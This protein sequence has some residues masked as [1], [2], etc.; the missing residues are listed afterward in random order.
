V[1]CFAGAV[2]AFSSNA[3]APDTYP[4]LLLLR[5]YDLPNRESDLTSQL[6]RDYMAL[7]HIPSMVSVLAFDGRVLHQNGE[8]T[9]RGPS[10]QPH[11][12]SLTYLDC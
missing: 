4:L 8:S 3:A 7:S 6:K 11:L 9:C 10:R 1:W 12:L 5:Q 2:P